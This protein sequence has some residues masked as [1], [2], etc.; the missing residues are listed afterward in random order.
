MQRFPVTQLVF[1]PISFYFHDC[2]KFNF[3]D[4]SN[5]G[6]KNGIDSGNRRCGNAA[7]D[8]HNNVCMYACLSVSL[9]ESVN[10][11]PG[12]LP[13]WNALRTFKPGDG[14]L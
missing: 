3:M 11:L 7:R 8:T 1:N 13:T 12:Y 10:Q 2:Q 6:E 5:Y 9:T 14:S 4:G